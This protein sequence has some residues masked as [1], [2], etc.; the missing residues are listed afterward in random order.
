MPQLCVNMLQYSQGQLSCV[1]TGLNTARVNSVVWKLVTTHTGSTQLCETW[2]TTARV[3]SVV[4]EHALIQPGLT[5]YL[6]LVP[7]IFKNSL[8][9]LAKSF[10]KNCLHCLGQNNLQPC[11]FWCWWKDLQARATHV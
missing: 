7:P 11:K 2:H 5:K 10:L 1:G 8:L 9:I 6:I 4:W 3:N